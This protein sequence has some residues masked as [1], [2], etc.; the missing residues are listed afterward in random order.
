IFEYNISTNTFSKKLDFDSS[1]GSNPKGSLIEIEVSSLGNEEFTQSKVDVI[2]WPNPVND[3]IH[4]K[5]KEGIQFHVNIYNLLGQ[6]LQS[7][8]KFQTNHQ[9]NISYLCSGIYILKVTKKN[10]NTQTIKFKKS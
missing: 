3:M 4:V 6:E 10:G 5:S 2:L 8:N 1:N 7:N 9:L